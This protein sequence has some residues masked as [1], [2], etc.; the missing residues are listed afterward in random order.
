MLIEKQDLPLVAMEFMN[1]TH[2][3]D[4][5]IINDLFEL[6]LDYEK[7]PDIHNEVKINSKY[8]QWYDHTVEHFKAEEVMMLEKNFPPYLFHKAEH[9][10]A[11]KVMDDLFEKWIDQKDINI[12]KQYFIETLPQ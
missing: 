10:N 9:D 5:E 3:E 6:I 4:M 11:L 1:D 7:N 2:I 8:K 12:L